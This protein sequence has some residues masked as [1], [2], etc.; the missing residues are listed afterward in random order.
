MNKVHEFFGYEWLIPC[1]DINFL[2]FWYSLEMKYR[3]N[4]NLYE[5]YLLNTL[6]KKYHVDD[7]KIIAQYS[8]NKII[9]KIKYFIGGIIR[10][11]TLPMGISIKRN[12][13]INNFSALE[14]Q[15]YKKIINKNIIV[16]KRS[17]LMQLLIIYILE[18]RYGAENIKKLKKSFSKNPLY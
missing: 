3:I 12:V 15:L 10:R 17:S 2:N 4:Q 6:F 9:T 16:Y 8:K 7:K 18:Q 11:I 5:E 1:W 14:L 13:D